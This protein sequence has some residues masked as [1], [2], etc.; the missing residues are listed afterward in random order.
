[1][2]EEKY[3][4]ITS[5]EEYINIIRTVREQYCNR[6]TPKLYFR[7]EADESYKLSPG[8]V[9][10]KVINENELITRAIQF[11]PEIFK[12]SSS[13]IELL[14]KLQ[15]Y[16]IPT[17]LLDITTNALVA[18]FF[19]CLSNEH[20]YDKNGHVYLL[21]KDRNRNRNINEAINI[22]ANTYKISH[23]TI[24]FKN[25][26]EI[27]KTFNGYSEFVTNLNIIFESIGET[28]FGNEINFEDNEYM[29]YNILQ[30][31]SNN[32]IF[33][34]AA[35]L[36]DRIRIQSGDFLLF[37]NIIENNDGDPMVN[38]IINNLDNKHSYVKHKIIV[39]SKCKNQILKDLEL[40]NISYSSLF[41][42]NIDKN[43]EIIKRSICGE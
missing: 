29:I 25:Y 27:I 9:R 12:T 20:E 23:E 35:Y 19:A 38:S 33:V 4:T 14:I 37:S 36:F 21:V 30:Y 40:F 18:L 41:Y 22:I 7:G 6:Y 32:P 3:E 17:R 15:H 31:I 42:D 26:L 16:G 5:I 13:A 28:R 11:Y 1:M 2:S 39:D 24:S 8:L 43:C 10:A 34:N